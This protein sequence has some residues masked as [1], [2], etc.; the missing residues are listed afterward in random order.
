MENKISLSAIQNAFL[1]RLI[2]KRCRN[3]LFENEQSTILIE[4]FLLRIK[5]D[6]RKQGFTP[7]QAM[8][9]ARPYIAKVAPWYDVKSFPWKSGDKIKLLRA[10][11]LGEAISLTEWMWFQCKPDRGGGG[12]TPI[13]KGKDI[14]VQAWM[15][16]ARRQSAK[17]RNLKLQNERKDM[18]KIL[19]TEVR[20]LLN[21]GFSYGAIA[22]RFQAEHRK[23][24][25]ARGIHFWT[26]RHVFAFDPDR[27]DP[28]HKWLYELGLAREKR[29]A[30]I[31][32]A[33]RTIFAKHLEGEGY[34]AI[35]RALN[36]RGIPSRNGGKWHVTSVKRELARGTQEGTQN[37][38]F[39]RTIIPR[40]NMTGE[41]A[42]KPSQAV[43]ADTLQE[44]CIQGLEDRGR[45]PEYQIRMVYSGTDRDGL[46]R[47]SAAIVP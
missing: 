9:I 46:H 28:D 32:K 16:N 38:P 14:Y 15:E 17:R 2:W 26:R 12:V 40:G 18:R 6:S 44:G 3:R 1:K 22:E 24:P 21:E 31:E 41:R 27:K 23:H 13:D 19:E 11:A 47:R 35:A 36:E 29:E 34:G 45:G 20:R 7:E 39:P 37:R 25:T 42:A 8:D 30:Q 4:Q 5:I 10:K 33:R 43:A